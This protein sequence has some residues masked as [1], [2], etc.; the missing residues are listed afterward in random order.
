MDAA[1]VLRGDLLMRV[2]PPPG[3]RSKDAPE[4]Y[5]VLV[6]NVGSTSLKFKLFVFDSSDLHAPRST[7]AEGRLEGI[8]RPRSLYKV[9]VGSN[10]DQ[11]E[12]SFPGYDDALKE[13]MNCLS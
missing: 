9:T 5:T 13:A 4:M 8:G 12:T 1:S 6:V 7:P 10:V 3:N 11:G 2:D